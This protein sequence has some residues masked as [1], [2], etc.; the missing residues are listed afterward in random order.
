MT[1]LNGSLGGAMA[2]VTRAAALGR[3]MGS[4][5]DALLEAYSVTEAWIARAEEL[6]R[7]NLSLQKILKSTEVIV[8]AVNEEVVALKK[9]RDSLVTYSDNLRTTNNI[10]VSQYNELAAKFDQSR[11]N[12]S[13]SEK[14]HN[15]TGDSLDTNIAYGK[16]VKHRLR[17]MEKALKYSSADTEALK[18]ILKPYEDL[19]ARLNL[20]IE[21]PQDL[22][23][24]ADLVWANFN[25]G[26][27]LTS[28]ELVQNIIDEA[29]QPK[30]TGMVGF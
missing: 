9:Q 7:D 22:R 27:I 3:A 19:V 20:N 13:D 25:N 16:Q 15:R 14:S 18:A 29:P 5:K 8:V 2:E 26:I 12:L 6:E 28:N 21:L 4:A 23:E 24:K 11:K 17:Q 30:A 10:L 1:S